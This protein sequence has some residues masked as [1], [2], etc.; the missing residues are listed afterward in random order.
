MNQQAIDILD[1]MIQ[2]LDFDFDSE[3]ELLE[4]AKSRIQTLQSKVPTITI[5][6]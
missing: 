2:E 6:E 4:Q 5:P 3:K 1:E